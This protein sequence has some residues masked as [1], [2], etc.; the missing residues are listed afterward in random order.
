[1][2]VAGAE[3]NPFASLWYAADSRKTKGAA[4][5]SLFE[6]A[7]SREK[8][9]FEVYVLRLGRGMQGGQS[10]YNVL[11]QGVST[12]ISTLLVARCAINTVLDGRKEDE[13]GRILENVDCL[14]DDWAD[15]NTFTDE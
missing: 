9:S 4:E 5:K 13:G 2:S 15:I 14:G 3:Q 7:D 11:N 6:L 8:G 10:I 12:S 1:M